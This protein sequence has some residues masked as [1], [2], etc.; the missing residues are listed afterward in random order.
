METFA[1]ANTINKKESP[2]NHNQASLHELEKMKFF[3][4]ARAFANTGGGKAFY[5]FRPGP[6]IGYVRV[7]GW[8]PSIDE[9]LEEESVICRNKRILPGKW[10]NW[11]SLL[12]Q[13]RAYVHK[14]ASSGINFQEDP[15]RSASE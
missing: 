15:R 6:S 4:M 7:Q 9:D 1:E 5:P 14:I 12:S 8:I 13:T 11:T 3:G 10:H 2:M